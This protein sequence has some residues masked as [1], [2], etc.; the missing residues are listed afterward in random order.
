M[1]ASSRYAA[2][3]LLCPLNAFSARFFCASPFSRVQSG[4]ERELRPWLLRLISV[5]CGGQAGDWMRTFVRCNSNRR[6]LSRDV[7]KGVHKVIL[8][9]FQYS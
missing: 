4:S 3:F 8:C 9:M 7:F 2:L 5:L 1:G 6:S